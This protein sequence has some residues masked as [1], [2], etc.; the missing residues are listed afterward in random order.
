MEARLEFTGTGGEL[1]KKLIVG[2]LLTS[3]TFGIYLPWF[4]VALDKYILEKTTLKRRGGDIKLEFFGTGGE[5][6]KIGFVGYLLSAITLGIYVPWFLVNVN[7]FFQANTRGR[8][9]DGSDYRLRSEITGG[10][11]LKAALVGYLLT[12]ITLGIYAPWFIVKLQK[13]FAD[14]TK[15]LENGQAVGKVAFLGTGGEL[16]GTMIVG[17]L[18]TALTLGIYGAWMQVNLLKFFAASTEVSIRG[19]AYRGEFSGKGGDL[20]VTMLVGYLLT[21]LT[22]GIYGFWFMAKLLKFQLDNLSYR[23]ATQQQLHEAAP[24]MAMAAGA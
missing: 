16:F 6:F 7:K 21:V 15:I 23:L 9:P 13:L 4:I 3:I 5:L 22:L 19:R 1:F 8:A 14:T 11:L 12:A 24:R 17:Y 20:F 18:L 10:Q 2:A